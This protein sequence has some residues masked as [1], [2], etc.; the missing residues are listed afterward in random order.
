MRNQ[1]ARAGAK[2]KGPRRQVTADRFRD[3]RHLCL[4]SI[5]ACATLLRVSPRTVRNWEAGTIRIPCAA[6]KLMRIPPGLRAARGR[7]GRLEL[8][9][10]TL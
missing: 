9:G 8:V 6:F 10:D 4:L 2:A 7:V 3:A 1:G 5:E